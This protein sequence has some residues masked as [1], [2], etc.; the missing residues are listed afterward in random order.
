MQ[1]LVE[2]PQPLT[3]LHSRFIR[4]IVGS[5]GEGVDGG[6]VRA[7]PRRQQMRGDREVL[8]VI[9]CKLLASGV[10]RGQPR[11]Y[12]SV[13][14]AAARRFTARAMTKSRSDSRLT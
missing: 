1:P 13:S 12:H 11:V 9:A 7:H 14:A 5:A 8:V 2:Q 3:V 6:D 10:R 4:E